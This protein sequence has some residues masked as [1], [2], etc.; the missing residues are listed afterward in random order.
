MCKRFLLSNQFTGIR[1][2]EI[3]VFP[4]IDIGNALVEMSALMPGLAFGLTGDP[5][6]VPNPEAINSMFNS[7][8]RAYPDVSA[9]GHNLMCEWAGTLVSIDGTSASSPIFA[10]ILTRLNAARLNAGKSQLGFAN[11]LLYS[12]AASNPSVFYDITIGDNK[13]AGFTCCEYG[14]ACEKGFDAVSGLGSV[15]DFALLEKLVVSMA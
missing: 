14:Y 7:T 15:G 2:R 3:R 1:I 5:E 11:P 10:G 9:I 8:L 12:L 13:C 4:V 6:G